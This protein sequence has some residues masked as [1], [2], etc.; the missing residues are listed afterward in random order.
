[1]TEDMHERVLQGGGEKA[2]RIQ[3]KVLNVRQIGKIS[4]KYRLMS[5][6]I[7]LVT[8]GKRP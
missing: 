5:K 2:F 1:V 6:G 8:G 3:K 7:S 4:R